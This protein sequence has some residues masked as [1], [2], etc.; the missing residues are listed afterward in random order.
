MQKGQT[1]IYKDTQRHSPTKH[2]Q[3]V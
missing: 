2:Y 3:G 1:L